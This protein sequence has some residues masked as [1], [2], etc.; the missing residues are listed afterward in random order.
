VSSLKTW[1]TELSPISGAAQAFTAAIV[2][3]AILY[4]VD[5]EYND[6]RYPRVVKQAATSLV[7]R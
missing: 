5:P 3:V 7:G 1:A 4:A 6:G 2:A